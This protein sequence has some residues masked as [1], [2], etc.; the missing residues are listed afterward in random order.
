V[1]CP[2]SRPSCQVLLASDCLYSET[3]VRPLFATAERLLKPGGVFV[4]AH[5]SVGRPSPHRS[6]AARLPL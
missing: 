4:L 2:S 5:I 6:A 1:L 3:A